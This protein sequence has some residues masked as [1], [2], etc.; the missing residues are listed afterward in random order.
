MAFLR[1][2]LAFAVTMA[3]VLVLAGLFIYLRLKDEFDHSV[4]SAVRSRVATIASLIGQED[5]GLSDLRP[6]GA[7]ALAGSASEF[8]AILDPGGAVLAATLTGTKGQA[9]AL[10]RTQLRRASDRP[11][12]TDERL[13]PG[14]GR[15]FRVYAE[16]VEAHGRRL[17]IVA[18]S[19]LAGRD[20]ALRRLVLLLLVAG[21]V[22]LVLATLA[23]YALAA[24]ALRP[25]EAMR[26]RAI[27][28]S[29]AQAGER[30]PI[31]RARDEIAR[32]GDSLN[33]MLDRL[34]SAL[35]LE[36]ALV[37]DASHELRTPLG[38]VK[39]ELELALYDGASEH[40]LRAAIPPRRRK[41]TGRW[42]SP[43]TSSFSPA[44]MRTTCHCTSRPSRS[45]IS[46]RAHWNASGPAP[47]TAVKRST[48][49]PPIDS[50]CRRIA[51]ARRRR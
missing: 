15:R 35:A 3:A 8:A 19:S 37:A 10:P 42:R 29:A 46:S 40:E 13:T 45:A 14:A 30:L 31:P 24:A 9:V 34:Q 22:A 12:L 36:R 41:T 44:S 17:V 16:P 6:P 28:I 18:G 21:P 48:P 43:R 7:P 33:E 32:L 20:A 26:R 23:A 39:S 38:L 2:T 27:G 1:L 25:V 5:S 47:P 4:D 51:S 49:S 50:S 11:I